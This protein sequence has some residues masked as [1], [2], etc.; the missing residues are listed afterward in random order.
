MQTRLRVVKKRAHSGCPDGTAALPGS[1]L[2]PAP[3]ISPHLLV[4]ALCFHHEKHIPWDRC[5]GLS[6]AF[7]ISLSLL[8]ENIQGCSIRHLGKVEI[9]AC[10]NLCS[11]SGL[12]RSREESGVVLERGISP[13]SLAGQ[14]S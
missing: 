3:A 13:Y 10:G 12:E 14:S 5:P 8:D 6:V 4:L 2:L 1:P 7:C 11:A 9:Q